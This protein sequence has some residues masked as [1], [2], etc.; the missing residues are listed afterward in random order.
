[1]SESGK[2]TI[3]VIS[4]TTNETVRV[5]Q[6]ALEYEPDR[7]HL[8]YMT[9]K[10]SKKKEFF[11]C[12]VEEIE[13]RIKEKRDVEVIRHNDTVYS[14]S[15]MLRLVNSIIKDEKERCG[16]FLHIYVN[17]SSGSAE[18]AAAA[19]AA[20]MMNKDCIPFTV[21]VKDHTMSFEDYQRM[22]TKDGHVIG[23]A[24]TVY[25]PKMIETF[26]I[27]PPDE[28]L[29]RYLRFFDSLGN[30]PHTPATIIRLLET[31][32]IW[33]YVPVR[34]ENTTKNA[35]TMQ[36]NRNVLQ[37]LK[38]KGW[39]IEGSSKNRF[40]ITPAG[41]AILDIFT[42]GEMEIKELIEEYSENCMKMCRSLMPDPDYRM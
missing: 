13:S 17:I 25:D 22:V 16:Q 1:M 30:R 26:N 20:C 32:G 31:N 8:I 33:R 3:V 37:P 39:L 36:Y 5:Y 11:E 23:N 10:D 2:R 29:V 27:E 21:A 9:K 38:D 41:R 18:Y 12:L 4:C 24:L 15:R 7:L 19:M 42:D 35:V 28:V 40:I 6:P 34:K 14:F